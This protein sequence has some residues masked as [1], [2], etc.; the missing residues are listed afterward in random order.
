MQSCHQSWHANLDL[1]FSSRDGITRLTKKKHQGPLVVQKALYP[2]GKG[3]CHVVMLHPPSGLA[4]GDHLFTS[5]SVNQD[6][7]AVLTTPGATRWY[8]SNGRIASQRTDIKIETGA[9][10]DYLPHENIFFDQVVGRSSLSIHQAVGSSLIA[11]DMIQLGRTASG[12]AWSESSLD[13]HASLHLDQQPVWIDQSALDS[14][15][16]SRYSMS[17]LDG[18]RVFGTMWMSSTLVN[19]HLSEIL[20]ANMP[21]GSGLRSGVSFMD[22]GQQHGLMVIRA[23]AQ[24]VEDIRQLFIQTWL[25]MRE[26]V[27]GLPAQSLRLWK[28]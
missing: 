5:V 4:G 14:N 3:V 20:A 8:K 15:S 27:C 19:Q 6:A 25:R 1:E 28:T 17:G 26:H 7:Q 16:V 9:H 18:H 10:L 12:E 23:L 11:W 24:E 21:W 2:E 22:I 13:M